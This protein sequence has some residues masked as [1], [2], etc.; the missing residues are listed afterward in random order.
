VAYANVHER[1]R[2][3]TG[4]RALADFLETSPDVPVPCWA[5]FLVFPQ[6]GTEDEKRKE[7]DNIAT[8]IGASVTDDTENYGHYTTSRAFGPVEYRAVLIPARSREYR[9]AQLSYSDNVIPDTN[10]EA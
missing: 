6:D 5:D 2:L 8:L 3:I 4:L 10:K 7:I 9:D 1:D